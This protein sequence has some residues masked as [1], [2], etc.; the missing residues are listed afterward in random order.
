MDGLCVVSKVVVHFLGFLVNGGERES[1]FD[2]KK[3]REHIL[4]FFFP[5]LVF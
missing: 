2:E 3:G 5:L 1:D 4:V